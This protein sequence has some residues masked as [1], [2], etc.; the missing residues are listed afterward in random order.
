M[1]YQA[2]ILGGGEKAGS[3]LFPLCEGF[4]KGL[5]PVCNKPMIF[6]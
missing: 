3:M 5:L 6:Y 2:I 1:K 4:S